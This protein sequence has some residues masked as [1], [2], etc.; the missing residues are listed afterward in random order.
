M[1]QQNKND[2]KVTVLSKISLIQMKIFNCLTQKAA[3]LFAVSGYFITRH[4]LSHNFT[5]LYKKFNNT[6]NIQHKAKTMHNSNILR[7]IGIC[8][9]SRVY[10]RFLINHIQISITSFYSSSYE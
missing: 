2:V 6:E 8:F 5:I 1:K 10:D 7:F 4:V 9:L 3:K